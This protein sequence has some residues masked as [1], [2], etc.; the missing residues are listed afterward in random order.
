MTTS[1]KNV[2]IL[3]A[4]IALCKR[5]IKLPSIIYDLGYKQIIMDKII[6][7]DGDKTVMPDLI[8]SS[9]E[10]NHCVIWESKSGRNIDNDQAKRLACIKDKVFNEQLMLSVRIE[11]DFAFD[12]AYASDGQQCQNIKV[13]LDR[14]AREVATVGTFPLVGFH[15]ESGLKTHSGRF[16]KTN[17]NNILNNGI[18][19]DLREVPTE[20]LR[21]D[22]DSPLSE[23]APYVM[24]NIVSYAT[25]QESRFSSEQIAKDSF[26]SSWGHIASNTIKNEI[27]KKIDDILFDAR[28]N[29]LDGYLTK[30]GKGGIG[31]LKWNLSYMNRSGTAFPSRRLKKLQKQC[32]EFVNRLK[33]EEAGIYAKQ[34][35]LPFFLEE[36]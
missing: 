24:I 7:V 1:S 26:G 5:D 35:R 11:K 21:F 22:K 19:F 10:E 30:P 32:I 33:N 8:M 31:S 6:R 28:Q 9:R 25:R 17:I 4:L 27:A 20:Y 14:V 12:I 3:R 2:L 34:L 16:K 15:T 23:I 18:N 36:E 29:E 13:D